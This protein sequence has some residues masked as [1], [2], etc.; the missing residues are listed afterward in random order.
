MAHRNR[1]GGKVGCKLAVHLFESRREMREDEGGGRDLR[2][3]FGLGG[4]HVIRNLSDGFKM[5]V[6]M[7]FGGEHHREIQGAGQKV[8]AHLVGIIRLYVERRVREGAAK[9]GGPIAQIDRRQVI[10]NADAHQ[11]GMGMGHKDAALRLVP[12][13][14]QGAGMGFKALALGREFGAGARA[15]EKTRAQGG[16]QGL[17]AGGDGG[18]GQA[19]AFRCAVEGP[20]FGQIKKG[21]QKVGLHCVLGGGV[22]GFVDQ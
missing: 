5:Q 22:I 18:L 7:G 15:G 14:A 6:G 17:D 19:K 1:G 12:F 8:G 2:Q 20:A 21:V 10:L 4:E 13:M 9:P 16:L 3:R 11:M